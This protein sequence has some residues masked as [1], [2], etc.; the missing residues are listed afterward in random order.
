M[1]L[2]VLPGARQA[3]Y[4]GRSKSPHAAQY[5]HMLHGLHAL[6][7]APQSHAFAAHLPPC[8]KQPLGCN[9]R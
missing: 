2:T 9:G 8:T 6:S 5:A 1:R 4:S 3:K 7:A